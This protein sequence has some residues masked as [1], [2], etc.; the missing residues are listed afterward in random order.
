[1]SFPL[2]LSL[3]LSLAAAL[4]AALVAAGPASALS[5]LAPSVASTYGYAADSPANYV[6]A[7]GS[8]QATGPSNPPQGAVAQGG[9][10]NMMA[11]YTQVAQFSGMAFTGE[12][13]TSPLTTRIVADVTCVAAWCGSYADEANALFFFRR[14]GDGTHVLEINA[15]PGNVF[16]NPTPAQLQQV[17]QCYNSGDC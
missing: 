6:V 7:V 11:G 14:D 9:D 17:T 12:A 2:S 4:A 8:L 5:C 3:S 15:C 16:S 1:M 10:I 13:F